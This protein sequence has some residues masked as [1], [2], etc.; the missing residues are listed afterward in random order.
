[1]NEKLQ[2]Y[3]KAVQEQ[4]EAL[5][6]RLQKVEQASEEQRIAMDNLDAL[7]KTLTPQQIAAI[8]EVI[9]QKSRRSD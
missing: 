4:N 2:T 3:V 6:V 8:T 7:A 1:M 5:Q 9:A